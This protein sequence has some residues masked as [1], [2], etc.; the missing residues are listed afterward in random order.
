[1]L[2]AGQIFLFIVMKT[3]QEI[4]DEIEVRVIVEGESDRS[5]LTDF[6][7]ED[8]IPLNGKP[9][10][11]VASSVSKDFDEALVLT[12]FDKEGRKISKK[13]NSFLTSFGVVPK[14]K[15]RG[16]IKRV[17]TKKGISAI[18]NLKPELF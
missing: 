8:V 13:L 2:W 17:V 12:D 5:T 7:I 9:L 15:T 1:M 10:Y 14:N 6:G 11:K 16:K 18:E 4:F 3:L